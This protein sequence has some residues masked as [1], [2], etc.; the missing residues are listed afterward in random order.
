MPVWDRHFHIMQ[1][2]FIRRNKRGKQ[3]TQKILV[4]QDT[5]VLIHFSHQHN[6]KPAI[7][8]FGAESKASRI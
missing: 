4:K 7:L 6:R 8:P 5:S 1:K 3:Y 2:E